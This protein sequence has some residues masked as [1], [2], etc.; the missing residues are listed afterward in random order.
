MAQTLTIEEKRARRFAFMREI[1]QVTDGS[2][3]EIVDMFEIGEKFGWD[4][5][6]TSNVVDYLASEGLLEYMTMGGGIGITHAGAVEVEESVSHPEKPTHHFPP[7]NLIHIGS[8]VNS[9]LIQDSAGSHQ[10]NV[11]IQMASLPDISNLVTRF[12]ADEVLSSAELTED[13]RDE[14]RVE[15]QSAQL[16][17]Q[18]KQPKLDRVRESMARVAQL[19]AGAA[20]AGG[21]LAKLSE[22]AMEIHKLVPGI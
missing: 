10:Q 4:Q 21:G 17:L 12:L 5:A 7:V 9:S 6:E 16:Q 22:Y 1:Y 11:T 2:R 13:D 18:A 15:L 19:S 14:L 20:L 8:M 3:M